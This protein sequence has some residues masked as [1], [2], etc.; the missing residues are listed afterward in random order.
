MYV[1]KGICVLSSGSKSR[2]FANTTLVEI[3]IQPV[4]KYISWVWAVL[5]VPTGRLGEI[6]DLF[7]KYM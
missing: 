1:E 2:I 5:R 3:R 7:P 6:F 4:H